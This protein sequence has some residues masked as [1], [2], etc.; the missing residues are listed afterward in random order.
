MKSLLYPSRKRRGSECESWGCSGSSATLQ[1]GDLDLENGENESSL[2][3][4]M[5]WVDNKLRQV[6]GQDQGQAPGEEVNNA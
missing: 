1:L 4:G 3:S 6:R 2:L 5:F